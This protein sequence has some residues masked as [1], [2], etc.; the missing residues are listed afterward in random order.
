[1]EG[2]DKRG[3]K[4]AAEATDKFLITDLLSMMH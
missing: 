3:K 2:D 1:M 4:G